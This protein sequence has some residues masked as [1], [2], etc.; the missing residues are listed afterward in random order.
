MIAIRPRR[1]FTLIELLVVIAIIGI[2]AGFLLPAVQAA[3]EAA[4]RLRCANNLKQIGLAILSY[5]GA[6][7]SFPPGR[8]MTYDPRFAG[9]NPPCTATIVDKSVHVMILPWLERSVLY[10]AVNQDLSILGRENRTVHAV[11]VS[12][13]ACPSDPDSGR[14]RAADAGIMARYGL[15]DPGESLS[16]VYTSYAVV[17]GSFDV[18]ALPRPDTRCVVP[19]PLAAQADGAFGDLAPIRSASIRDGMGSTLFA[20]ERDTT[21]LR[22]LDVV[23]PALYNRHGW[24]ATGNLGDTLATTFY[25][26]NMMEKV[27]IAAGEAHASAPSSLHPGGLNAL[28]GDGSVRFVKHTVETWP[29]HPL[30]GAPSGARRDP[31]GWWTNL[32][33]PGVWQKLAS[34]AGGEVLDQGD[35]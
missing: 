28:M 16:M 2:L 23:D 4:R 18:V 15:A 8:M 13:F 17:S 19:G 14:A 12:A 31:G 29:Y 10:N 32:P 24:Y 22:N 34:R 9:T 35:Y 21:D 33:P 3:R 5:E 1:G 6:F 27:A 11:A 30:T 25:P 26:P 7:G 20:V